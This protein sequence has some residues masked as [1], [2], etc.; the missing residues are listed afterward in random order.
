MGDFVSEHGKAIKRSAITAWIVDQVNKCEISS[1]ESFMVDKVMKKFKLD[2]SHHGVGSDWQ[3]I[4]KIIGRKVDEFHNKMVAET[5]TRLVQEAKATAEKAKE[6]QARLEEM[7]RSL[8][9][10][11]T[12]EDSDDDT[13]E[14]TGP[15]TQ[16]MTMQHRKYIIYLF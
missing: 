3:K 4:R 14:D 11:T 1:Q 13:T 10:Q 5:A 15:N 8:I 12:E 16:Y 6:T 2:M 7:E 9:K